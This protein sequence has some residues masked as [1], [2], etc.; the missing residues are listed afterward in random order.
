MKQVAVIYIKV[1]PI[2][3]KKEKSNHMGCGLMVGVFVLHLERSGSSDS[4]SKTYVVHVVLS[5]AVTWRRV[6]EPTLE[7]SFFIQSKKK[8]K[9]IV[10]PFFVSLGIIFYFLLMIQ[11]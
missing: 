9:K 8:K 2:L 3:I 10:P 5:I 4:P 1:C 6:D 11:S 7:T